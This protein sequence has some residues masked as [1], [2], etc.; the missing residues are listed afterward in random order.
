MRQTRSLFSWS[1]FPGGENG[2]NEKT[3][4]QLCNSYKC[5]DIKK[6][7]ACDI[8]WGGVGG[9]EKVWLFAYANKNAKDLEKSSKSSRLL[10]AMES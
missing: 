4:K 10:S 3:I 1:L 9:T 5:Y 2:L 8:D 7:R 6:T